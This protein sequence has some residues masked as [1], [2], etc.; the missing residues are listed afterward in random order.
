METQHVAKPTN[1]EIVR[2]LR[3]FGRNLY[4][5]REHVAPDQRDFAKLSNLDRST[6]SKVECGRQAPRFDTLL[7]LARAARVKPSE[8][9]YGIGPTQSLPKPPNGG[10]VR[11]RTAS[12]QF[13][14]NLKWAREQAKLSHWDLGSDA[15]ADRSLISDWEQGKREAG[16]RTILKL[17][18]ALEIPPAHLLHDV[19][20]DAGLQVTTR[21]PQ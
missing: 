14:A 15:A 11:R 20:P 4:A 6:I 18:R 2:D 9:L 19:E 3:M 13:G 16:L 12:A 7:T 17:A 8:L 21:T 10:N 1:A 5:A